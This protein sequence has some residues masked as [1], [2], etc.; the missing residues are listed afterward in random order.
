MIVITGS[1]NNNL[2]HIVTHDP[3]GRPVPKPSKPACKQQKNT[4]RS[5]SIRT[6]FDQASGSIRPADAKP[7]PVCRDFQVTA[8]F[9][10]TACPA[11]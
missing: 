9:Q 11:A 4:G 10:V 3:G 2:C 1:G 5:D 8:R 6:T 7:A